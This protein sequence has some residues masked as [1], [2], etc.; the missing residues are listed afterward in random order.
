MERAAPLTERRGRSGSRRSVRGTQAEEW[1][2]DGV[3]PGAMEVARRHKGLLH[4]D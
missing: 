3:E 4:L 1:S 2:Q